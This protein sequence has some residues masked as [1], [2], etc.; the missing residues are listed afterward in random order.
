MDFPYR[1]KD[2]MSDTQF[3]QMCKKKWYK[4][5]QRDLDYYVSAW[6][7][8]WIKSPIWFMKYSRYQFYVIKYILDKRYQTKWF[9]RTYHNFDWQCPEK[10]FSFFDERVKKFDRDFKENYESKFIQFFEFYYR[11]SEYCKPLFKKL[12]EETKRVSSNYSEMDRKFSDRTF[13]QEIHKSYYKDSPFILFGNEEELINWFIVK[14]VMEYKD[15][16]EVYMWNSLPFKSLHKIPEVEIVKDFM[17][18]FYMIETLEDITWKKLKDIWVDRFSPAWTFTYCRACWKNFMKKKK[19]SISCSE[20][21]IQINKNLKKK[22]M[23]EIDKNYW[24]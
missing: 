3:R 12:R 22:K 10:V 21:C 4:L 23:R 15:I 9:I 16:F 18:I 1:E 19:N 7:I 5:L 2:L 11:L 20:K 13:I 14:H 17:E 8:H 6:L 24:K